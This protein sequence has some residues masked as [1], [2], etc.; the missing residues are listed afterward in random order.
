MTHSLSDVSVKTVNAGRMLVILVTGSYEKMGDAFNQLTE[1]MAQK[2]IQPSGSYL[3]V[4]YDTIHDFEKD[5]VRYEVAVQ[6]DR[7]VEDEDIIKY[8]EDFTQEM[9][10]ITYTGAY[11]NIG[12]AYDTMLDWIEKNRYRINGASREVYLVSPLSG[13]RVSP[14]SYV[15]EIQFPVAKLQ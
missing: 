5:S 3:A 2:N 8:R 15:T 12:G 6:I 13:E 9:A 10:V 7:P 11:E 4:F 1:W 14:E